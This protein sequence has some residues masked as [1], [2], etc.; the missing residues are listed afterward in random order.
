[1]GAGVDAAGLQ[2]PLCDGSGD[3]SACC[4]YPLAEF[5]GVETS[6]GGGAVGALFGV[7][8]TLDDAAAD[9]G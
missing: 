4:V 2:E 1:M 5:G 8:G 3:V 9:A 6:G 7:V